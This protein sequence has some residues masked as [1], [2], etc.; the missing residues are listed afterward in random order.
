MI[1]G[2]QAIAGVFHDAGI[3]ALFR[4][5]E[6]PKSET[7]ARLLTDIRSTGIEALDDGFRNPRRFGALLIC[8]KEAGQTGLLHEILDVYQ[9]RTRISIDPK[10]HHA[11][12]V[13]AYLDF[14]GRDFDGLVN[15]WLVSQLLNHE[16]LIPASE[17]KRHEHRLN[18]KERALN[19]ALSQFFTLEFLSHRLTFADRV[20]RGVLKDQN[21]LGFDVETLSPRMN[22][23]IQVAEETQRRILR[24]GQQVSLVLDGYDPKARGFVFRW[25]S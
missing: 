6:P 15:Q 18:R 4:Y 20:L 25:P 21:E 17:L 5:R 16:P 14:K 8:L 1:A 19:S 7:V 3:S 10:P 22:G 2:R 11:L 12:G 13:K 24:N 23:T 9:G